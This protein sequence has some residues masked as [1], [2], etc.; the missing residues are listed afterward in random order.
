MDVQIGHNCRDCGQ[1]GAPV[2]DVTADFA[3][4][5]QVAR[6]GILARGFDHPHGWRAVIATLDAKN[7]AG[8]ARPLAAGITLGQEGANHAARK[9]GRATS[10]DRLQP[11]RL[12]T[13]SPEESSD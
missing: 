2:H 12:L 10:A 11:V 1:A 4:G 6:G 13:C 5:A 9:Q 3:K 7:H 8:L